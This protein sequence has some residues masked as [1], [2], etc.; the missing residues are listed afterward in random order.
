MSKSKKHKSLRKQKVTT[1]KAIAQK[2]KTTLPDFL[3]NDTFFLI[4][5]IVLS[6][7]YFSYSFVSEGFYQQ[8]GPAHYNNMRA[9]WLNPADLILSTWAK[10]GFKL[11]YVVPALIGGVKGAQLLSSLFSAFSA[12][13]AYKTAKLFDEKIAFLAFVLVATSHVWFNLSFRLYSE[14]CTAFVLV[15]GVYFHLKDKPYIAALAFSYLGFIRMELYAIGGLYFLF[16]LY[17]K[18][19]LPALVTAIFPF[20]QNLWGG[21]V[22]GEPLFLL[23][24]ITSTSSAYSSAWPKMGFDHFFKFFTEIFGGIQ[25][26]LFILYMGVLFFLK[27]NKKNHLFVL[28]PALVY[29][30]I[31]TLFNWQT[32]EI[33]PGTGGNLRYL[34]IIAPLVAIMGAVGVKEFFRIEQRIPILTLLIVLFLINAVFLSYEVPSVS[35]TENRKWNGSIMI[36]LVTFLLFLPEN[37]LSY[38]RRLMALAGLAILSGIFVIR[39]YPLAP[40]DKIMKDVASWYANQQANKP[41]LQGY[42]NHAMLYFYLGKAQ[43]EFNPPMEIIEENTII[44][45]PKGAIFLWESHYGYRPKRNPNHVSYTYFTEKPNQFKLLKQFQSSD[46]RFVTLA[47]EKL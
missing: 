14:M 20:I 16:L 2:N 6:V 47:F 18:K 7:I 32:V 1:G 19:W 46:K 5:A 41:N 36:G 29:F 15:L 27:D 39:P 42:C 4:A 12:F 11:F 24:L 21:L 23:N 31:Q 44:N 3:T 25:T 30:T 13:F 22:T 33:G 9:F 17:E 43:Q 38:P 37:F 28:F 45:A 8:D 40:E 10:V 35:F 34:I 26:A